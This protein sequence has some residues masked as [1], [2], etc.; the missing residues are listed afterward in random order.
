MLKFFR[1]IFANRNNFGGARVYTAVFS[2]PT[3]F[4]FLPTISA[5]FRQSNPIHLYLSTFCRQSNI[6]FFLWHARFAKCK[7]SRARTHIWIHAMCMVYCTYCATQQTVGTSKHFEYIEFININW[8][9]IYATHIWY[10]IFR[11]VLAYRLTIF[12]SLLVAWFDPQMYMKFVKV[13][14]RRTRLCAKSFEMK[15]KGMESR[16]TTNDEI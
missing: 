9:F 3:L 4:I 6:Q 8:I 11:F 2:I 5:S 1:S 7:R 15:K 16:Q 14:F 12:F 13:R 10:I